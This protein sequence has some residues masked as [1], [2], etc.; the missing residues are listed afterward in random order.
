[1]SVQVTTDCDT[2][3][4]SITYTD[5]VAFRTQKLWC[6]AGSC[7]SSGVLSLEQVSLQIYTHDFGSTTPQLLQQ[8]KQIGDEPF[9]VFSMTIRFILAPYVPFLFFFFSVFWFASLCKKEKQLS[10]ST[11]VTHEKPTGSRT[12]TCP[13]IATEQSFPVLSFHLRPVIS[14]NP[15][16]FGC[17]FL[18]LEHLWTVTIF[19]LPLSYAGL[20]MAVTHVFLDYGQNFS[21]GFLLL[22]SVQISLLF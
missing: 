15:S 2:F 6:M 11:V 1:M 13:Q 7:W 8:F 21:G 18:L 5:T 14:E 9:P 12:C 4:R 22:G 16:T 19:Y 20:Q 17:V 10:R 3:W